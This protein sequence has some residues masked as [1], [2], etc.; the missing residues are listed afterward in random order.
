MFDLETFEYEGKLANM[1]R[2]IDYKIDHYRGIHWLSGIPG[3]HPRT[4]R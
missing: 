4:Y 1:V 2:I 3:K